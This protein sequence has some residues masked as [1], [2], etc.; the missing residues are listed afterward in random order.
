MKNWLYAMSVMGLVINLSHTSAQNLGAYTDSRGYFYVFENGNRNQVETM[1]IKYSKVGGNCVLYV[2]NSDNLKCYYQGDKIDVADYPP[3]MLVNTDD[4]GAF[5]NNRILYVVDHGKTTRMPGWTG[6]YAIGDSIVGC[7]DDNNTAY[8]V[9]YDG[10]VKILPDVVDTSV[11][12][13]TIAGDNILVYIAGG[14]KLKAYYHN[15]IYDLGTDHPGKYAAGSSTVAFMDLYS[16]QF[17]VFYD[18]L[19]APLESM[20]PKSFSCGDGIIAYVDASNNFK[21]FYKGSLMTVFSYAPDNYAVDDNVV[22]FSVDNVGF[23]VFYKG[24]IYK[25]ET[26]GP[27]SYQCDYNSVGYLDAY[28]YLKMFCDG[29]TT[30]CSDVVISK[31]KLTKNVLMYR[32]DLNE[33]NIFLNGQQY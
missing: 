1:P 9:Y 20:P 6:N 29:N 10:E 2:D 28:G 31:F 3:A 5:Y 13:S 25:M 27:M 8:N 33:F 32:T 17:K 16:Q 23:N 21:I 11:R 7:F 26:T 22:A 24:K 12:N 18:G 4:L 19:V 30:Q 14:G 15:K